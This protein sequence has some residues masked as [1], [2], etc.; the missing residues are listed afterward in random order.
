M[1]KTKDGGN[2]GRVSRASPTPPCSL[3]QPQPGNSG[4]TEGDNTGLVSGG[5][6][7]KRRHSYGT[8]SANHTGLGRQDGQLR[9][10]LQGAVRS[11]AGLRAGR[12]QEQK[13]LWWAKT[14]AFVITP[15]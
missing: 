14:L 11:A 13:A 5:H 9:L 15:P 7:L 2:R 12:R 1:N 8:S 4:V 10:T 6:T 3:R